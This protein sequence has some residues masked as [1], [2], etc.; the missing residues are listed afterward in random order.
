[1]TELIIRLIHDKKIV[2]YMTIWWGNILYVNVP[3][4]IR[5][6]ET[7]M[8]IS[9]PIFDSFN[10]GF[11]FGDKWVF[12]GD[13]VEI[14]YIFAGRKVISKWNIIYK[15]A[16]FQLQSTGGL[17]IINNPI[18][19]ILDEVVE[20]TVTGNIYETEASHDA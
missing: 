3:R 5:T 9:K 11:K 4:F 10:I 15:D 1:M 14:S 13:I 7:D 2:G 6:H 12:D 18:A 19:D 17:E 20:I 16:A 8:V